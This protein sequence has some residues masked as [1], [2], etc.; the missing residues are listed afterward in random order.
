V[1]EDRF[2]DRG[3]R[4]AEGR[5]DDAALMLLVTEGDAEALDSVF[6]RYGRA[7]YS[8]AAR[9]LV[10]PR[11]AEDVVQEVFCR[12]GSSPLAMTPRAGR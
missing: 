8:L 12:C 5:S 3:G 10:D 9:I 7:C 4:P 2:R 1:C 11:T 6:L